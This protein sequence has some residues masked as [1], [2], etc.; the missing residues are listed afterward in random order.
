MK[1]NAEVFWG[2]LGDFF[3]KIPL[4]RVWDRV[5]QIQITPH[6]SGDIFISCDVS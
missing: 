4:S 3:K 1:M 6:Y 5:P 2:Y